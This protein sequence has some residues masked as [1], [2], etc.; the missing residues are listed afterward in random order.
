VNGR[1]A[2]S[3][4][5]PRARLPAAPGLRLERGWLRQGYSLV[6]GI[7]EAGRGAWAGPVVAAAVI[8]PLSQRH[9]ARALRGVNDSKL[10][11]PAVRAEL[12]DLIRSLAVCVGVGGA[13]AAEVDRAG[14]VPA[15]RAAMQRAVAM[16]RP[17]P[18]ALLID[19]VDLTPA[20][21]LPQRWLNFGE[22]HSLSIAAASIVAKVSRD[23]WMAGLEGHYPGY[24]F[25][26]HKGYGTPAH[27]AALERLGPCEVHRRSFAPIRAVCGA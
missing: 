12:Y 23:R 14:L 1:A 6:A 27:W 4:R 15:T 17:A 10:L 5:A 9:L 25:A 22:S 13:S 11:P 18:E 2:T 21:G 24:G 19:A 8:L 7:D 20:V 3:R 26:Q 16:L